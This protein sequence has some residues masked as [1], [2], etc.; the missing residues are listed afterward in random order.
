MDS[1]SDRCVRLAEVNSEK[2]IYSVTSISCRNIYSLFP[3]NHHC[4]VTVRVGERGGGASRLTYII[5]GGHKKQ[6]GGGRVGGVEEWEW[7]TREHKAL[8]KMV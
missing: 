8:G 1:R 2:K 5:N 4:Y 7:W 6:W 3:L